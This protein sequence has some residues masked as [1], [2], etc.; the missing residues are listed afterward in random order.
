MVQSFFH[1][2]KQTSTASVMLLPYSKIFKGF[3]LPREWNQN[4]SIWS[5][6][7]PPNIDYYSLHTF[8]PTTSAQKQVT[9]HQPSLFFTYPGMN[10]SP[11]SLPRNL[12]VSPKSNGTYHLHTQWDLAL[13]K[14][15]PIN[16]PKMPW[17]PYHLPT[18]PHL[19]GEGTKV[20]KG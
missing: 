7:L 19:T 8:T 14:W 9:L 5:S 2:I 16:P 12:S 10:R 20:Q 1:K 17:G 18:Q 4:S 13:A 15:L 6:R 11:G 3:L